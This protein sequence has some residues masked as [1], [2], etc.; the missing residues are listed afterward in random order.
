MLKG[1]GFV[2]YEREENA[3]LAIEQE[4]GSLYKGYRIG[5]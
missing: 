5:M 2:Q 4:N 3:R 1:Y